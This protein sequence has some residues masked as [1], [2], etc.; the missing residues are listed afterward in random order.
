MRTHISGSGTLQKLAIPLAPNYIPLL[1]QK[2]F[3]FF[4]SFLPLFFGNTSKTASTRFCSPCFEENYESNVQLMLTDTNCDRL[5]WTARLDAASPVRLLFK[6]LWYVNEPFIVS[7]TITGSSSSSSN[8]SP[9]VG[10]FSGR[11]HPQ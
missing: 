5:V 4:L 1:F 6:L 3:P 11:P 9:N 7:S 8:S 10:P 2:L